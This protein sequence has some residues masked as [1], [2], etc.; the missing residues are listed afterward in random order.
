MINGLN[1]QIRAVVE[2][3]ASLF[4][5][6]GQKVAS[7]NKWVE[8]NQT[9]IDNEDDAK[10]TRQ[11]AEDMLRDLTL[12]AYNETGNKAPALGVGIREVTKLEY[13]TKEAFDWAIE[14]TM[15]IKLDTSAFTKIVKVSPPDFVKVSLEPQA[16]IA[17]KLEVIS[18]GG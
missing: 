10:N 7:Y 6:A 4:E 18:N 11:E 1:E 15:A 12:K 16:T 17:T 9:L 8:L 2:A 14:H 5:A 13:D 3:R